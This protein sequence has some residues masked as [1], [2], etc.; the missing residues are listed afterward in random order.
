[1][2]ST[3]RYRSNDLCVRSKLYI[4]LDQSNLFINYNYPMINLN[5]WES[6]VVKMP[7]YWKSHVMA[8]YYSHELT[9]KK[10]LPLSNFFLGQ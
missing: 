2:H 8:N 4:V 3:L 1:M 6:T 10:R 7:H 5:I 9:L